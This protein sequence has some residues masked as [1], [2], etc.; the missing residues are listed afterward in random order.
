MAVVLSKCSERI[1]KVNGK[2]KDTGRRLKA[3]SVV[4]SKCF[5]RICIRCSCSMEDSPGREMPPAD[6][7]NAGEPNRRCPCSSSSNRRPP[8]IG[9]LVM[10]RPAQ[11]KSVSNPKQRIQAAGKEERRQAAVSKIAHPSTK[12]G[13][14]TAGHL[15]GSVDNNSWSFA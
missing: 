3:T 11:S 14:K 12:L 4:L 8:K 7:S 10:R 13:C 15:E 2:D 9:D 1:C 5:E 6:R